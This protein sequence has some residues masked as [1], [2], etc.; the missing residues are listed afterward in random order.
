M[1]NK[2]VYIGFVLFIFCWGC[3]SSHKISSSAPFPEEVIEDA[4]CSEDS[5]YS[6]L[7]KNATAIVDFSGDRY[8]LD[9]SLYAEKDSFVF[10]SASAR[11]I[12]AFRAML[13]RDTVFVV[14]RI[15]RIVYQM[16]L[17]KRFG[18]KLPVNFRNLQWLVS[19]LLDCENFRISPFE[20]DSSFYW[21]ETDHELVKELSFSS[22]SFT[23]SAFYFTNRKSSL[24]LRGNRDKDRL[25]VKSN[26]MFDG[27]E[28]SV[29][30][31]ERF[32]NVKREINLNVNPR[33]YDFIEL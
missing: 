25:H 16:L 12:E 2:I 7:H 18:Y 17:N 23:L 15:N 14:D 3:K 28:F 21:V 30:G 19:P 24:F 6:I 13:T 8:E 1:S 22:T 20:Q 32:Y 5:V 10:I 33:K 4:F 26:L 29:W 27:L 11:G 9:M 31:G